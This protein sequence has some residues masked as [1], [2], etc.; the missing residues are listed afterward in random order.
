MW[1]I[2]PLSD[3]ALVT[4]LAVTPGSFLTRPPR[5]P[6]VQNQ[7]VPLFCAVALH[8]CG[9]AGVAW[10]GGSLDRGFHC[11]CSSCVGYSLFYY[12]L[13]LV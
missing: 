10:G 12:T 7:G 6:R 5:M 4:S 9:E 3:V 2:R 11:L 13:M 1:Y 8:G